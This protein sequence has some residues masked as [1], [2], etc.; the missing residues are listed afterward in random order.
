[1]NLKTA[2]VC[3]A[4]V[5]PVAGLYRGIKE[6]QENLFLPQKEVVVKD[7]PC[8]PETAG[9][10]RYSVNPPIPYKDT[11][12]VTTWPA[13]A[14]PIKKVTQERIIGLENPGSY[15]ERS[16][17]PIYIGSDTIYVPESKVNEICS[18]EIYNRPR[19]YG[20]EHDTIYIPEPEVAKEYPKTR[21]LTIDEIKEIDK[22]LKD[23]IIPSDSRY[24]HY[25]TIIGNE[26]FHVDV[27]KPEVV[28]PYPNLY[29]N[30]ITP[31]TPIDPSLKGLSKNIINRLRHLH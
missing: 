2:A 28:K 13:F 8:T 15:A 22:Q 10:H 16:N 5:I 17:K 7:V 4:L 9:L 29:K 24:S 31:Y 26:T 1:M 6:G 21:Q 23:K 14:T 20:T 11:V 19:P 27:I 18:P 25:N 3:T 30:P 12:E